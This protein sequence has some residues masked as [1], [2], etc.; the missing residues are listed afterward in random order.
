LEKRI[1]ILTTIFGGPLAGL[2][3]S[4]ITGVFGLIERRQKMAEKKLDYQH[5]VNL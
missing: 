3:G 2:L 1:G 5:E 4:L